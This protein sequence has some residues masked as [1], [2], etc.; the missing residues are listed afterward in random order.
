MATLD[1]P[2]G[3]AAGCDKGTCYRRSYLS[4]PWTRLDAYFAVLLT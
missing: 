3:I 2:Y 1:H 4:S